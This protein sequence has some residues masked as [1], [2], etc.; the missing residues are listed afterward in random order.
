ME[1]LQG[2]LLHCPYILNVNL[3]TYG[4][5]LKRELQ[6]SITQAKGEQTPNMDIQTIEHVKQQQGCQAVCPKSTYSVKSICIAA[7]LPL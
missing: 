4:N 5:E 1:S 3:N 2:L 7:L 6:R